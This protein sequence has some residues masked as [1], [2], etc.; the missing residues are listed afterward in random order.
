[1]S[2]KA[3]VKMGGQV[4]SIF[5]RRRIR[6]RRSWDYFFNIIDNRSP[7]LIIERIIILMVCGLT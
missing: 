3:M 2:L 7:I 6:R 4:V 5:R 1:M